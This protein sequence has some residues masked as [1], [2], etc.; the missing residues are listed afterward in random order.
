MRRA[1][2]GKQLRD[3]LDDTQHRHLQPGKF[4]ETEIYG[5]DRIA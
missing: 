5:T 4:D 2:D 1:A 3:S